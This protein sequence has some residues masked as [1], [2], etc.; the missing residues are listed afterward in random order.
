MREERNTYYTIQ[1]K[2][3]KNVDF[4][5]VLEFTACCTEH[6][7]CKNVVGNGKIVAELTGFV[8]DPGY[9]PGTEGYDTTF[10]VFD[11][12]SG[13]AAEALDVISKNLKLIDKKLSKPDFNLHCTGA[14]MLERGF[15]SP[16]HRGSRLLLR[17]MR[18]VRHITG[19]PV[20]MAILKAYPDGDRASDEDCRKLARYYASDPDLSLIELDPKRLVGWMVADWSEPT[21]NGVD[22]SVWSFRE[23]STFSA[24]A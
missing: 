14:V 10:D 22:R 9:L 18:E 19:A 20:R 7:T 21:V 11:S 6:D 5:W 17:L 23:V 24:E 2:V 3:S 15:V 1:S 8:C 4:N 16:E 13:H 12:R